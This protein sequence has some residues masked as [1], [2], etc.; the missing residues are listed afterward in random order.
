MRVLEKEV[1]TIGRVKQSHE[2]IVVT[3][4]ALVNSSIAEDQ[5]IIGSS[6]TGD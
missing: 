2:L 1:L 3:I 6:E 5:R 4:E